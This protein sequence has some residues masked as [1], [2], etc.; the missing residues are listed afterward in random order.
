MNILSAEIIYK[1][2]GDKVLLNHVSFGIEEGDRIGLIGVNGA[3]KSTLL[4][5][6]AGYESPESGTITLGGKVTVHYLPQEPVFDEEQSVLNQVFRGETPVMKLIRDYEEL[7]DFL[8]QSPDEKDKQEKLIR[9]QTKLDEL[10][11]WQLEHEAKTILT[12]LGITDFQ[13][14]VGTLSGGQRK[15]IALARALIQP[16]D[17]LI[18]D[19]P[20][21]H[22][23]NESAN[24]LEKYL[25]RRKGALLMI[26]HDRYFLDRVV[27]RIFELDNGQLYRYPGNYNTYLETKLAR[28]ADEQAT[29]EKRRNFLRN[30]L[31]WIKRG[32]RARGTK[33]KART[34]RY[35]ELLDQTPEAKSDLLEISTVSTRLGKSVIELD[36]VTKGYESEPVV[37]DFSYI[38]LRN[39]RIGII[40]PNG[41]GKSTLLKMMAGVL[42]P[43]SGFVEAG[44]TVKIGYFSQEHE[45]M[46][47]SKRVIEY[48]RDVAE[49]VET[50]D[51]ETISV[52]QMLERFLFPG[53]LQWTPIE[54]LSGGEKRRLALLRILVTAPNVLLLDEPTNDLDIPT[55][56]VLEAYLDDFPGAVVV[57]SHDRYFL[58]RV[59]EKIFALD[60]DGSISKHFGNYSDYLDRL[61]GEFLPETGEKKGK[62]DKTG[63]PDRIGKQDR[64][65]RQ[66]WS[67]K[68]DRSDKTGV[69]GQNKQL[70]ESDKHVVDSQE[71]SGEQYQRQRTLKFTYKEQKDYEEIDGKIANTEVELSE[72]NKLMDKA[73]GDVGKL[74]ELFAKQQSL[75]ATLNDLIER[76]TYLNELAE[77]IEESRR[78]FH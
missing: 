7:L 71:V 36:H 40:G 39:D 15:R 34:D 41:S 66:E 12:K 11:G 54:K 27:N 21:N 2:Y 73:C 29:E 23:D 72:V 50:A 53:P 8:E 64:Q 78:I 47:T 56:S 24:W 51:G 3:G 31:E 58:D 65:S 62:A 6:V 75:E 20:T 74:Q 10:D 9:L 25:Q 49:R 38:V 33:Q 45:E 52:S 22:I 32:P 19:E 13:A 59:A 48:I 1:S 68:Q 26:T 63:K 30:E 42:S 28:I 5:M 37:Q 44:Q 67:E 16:S 46:D 35:N 60:G 70:A 17:L 55:L 57:V 69:L 14:S 77:K 43:D 61:A 76:W 18:L 4:K